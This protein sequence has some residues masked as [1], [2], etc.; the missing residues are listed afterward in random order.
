MNPPPNPLRVSIPTGTLEVEYDNLTNSY[1]LV[2][3]SL[4]DDEDDLLKID[5]LVIYLR[6]I[7]NTA[8]YDLE[9]IL[10]DNESNITY[11]DK[12]NDGFLSKGDEFFIDGEIV[13]PYT[14]FK[15]VWFPWGELVMEVEFG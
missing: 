4:T 5:S 6:N 3:N 14:V 7:N 9:T 12:D 11:Y 2:V 10:D 13:E 15:A 8:W 1:R